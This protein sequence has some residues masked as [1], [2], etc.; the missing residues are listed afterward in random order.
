MS[1]CRFSDP[2]LGINEHLKLSLGAI[3]LNQGTIYKQSRHRKH[4]T[5]NANANFNF[6]FSHFDQ[7]QD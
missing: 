6:N 7:D 2:Q 4:Q 1:R 5:A 3:D